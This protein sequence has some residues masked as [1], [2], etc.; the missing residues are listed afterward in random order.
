MSK[1]WG[2]DFIYKNGEQNDKHEK[3]A[4]WYTRHKRQF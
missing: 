3:L 4:F 1:T 2:M